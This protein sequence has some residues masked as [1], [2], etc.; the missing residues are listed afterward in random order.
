MFHLILTGIALV[1]GDP[2]PTRAVYDTLHIAFEKNTDNIL[3]YSRESIYSVNPEIIRALKIKIYIPDYSSGRE[4]SLIN[5]QRIKEIEDLLLE[6]GVQIELIETNRIGEQ[7]EQRK[8]QLDPDQFAVVIRFY[9]IKYKNFSTANLVSNPECQRD[10]LIQMVR[11]EL[12]RMPFCDYI[13]NDSIPEIRLQ[14]KRTFLSEIRNDEIDVLKNLNFKNYGNENQN[15]LIPF[16]EKVSD[17]ELILEKYQDDTQCWMK[18][19]SNQITNEKLNGLNYFSLRIKKSGNYRISRVA[20]KIK[21]ELIL[22]PENSGIIEAFVMRNDSLMYP[23]E[24]VMGGK[25]LIASHEGELSEYSIL[26]RFISERGEESEVINI[27]MKE[28]FNK[29]VS[30]KRWES[31]NQLRPFFHGQLPSNAGLINLIDKSNMYVSR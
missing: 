28:C 3:D 27:S 30:T 2:E 29:T 21:N 9:P 6:E 17:K 18:L 24:I 20:K 12:I 22:A 31:N 8:L 11:G 23:A 1:S 5:Q 16:K 25:A 7:N 4:L 13:S 26:A 10:T 15:V 14:T 19:N